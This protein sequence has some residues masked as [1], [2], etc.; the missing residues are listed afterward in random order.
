MFLPFEDIFGI[1]HHSPGKAI[2]H[3]H[4]RMLR[5]EGKL[6]YFMLMINYSMT[7]AQTK[8]F[9][10]SEVPIYQ[11]FSDESAS[12]GK[13]IS[14]HMRSVMDDLVRL[15]FSIYLSCHL[16]FCEGPISGSC[17]LKLDVLRR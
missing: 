3:I 1:K 12:S 14:D 8:I 17:W 9:V 11:I 2:H 6:A 10:S 16:N 7:G 4:R 13:G 15:F 5:I